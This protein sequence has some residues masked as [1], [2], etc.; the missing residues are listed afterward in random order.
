ME[1]FLN[2]ARLYRVS[3]AGVFSGVL[4]TVLCALLVAQLLPHLGYAQA[5]GLRVTCAPSQA[6]VGRDEPVTWRAT[7]RGTQSPIAYRWRGVNITTVDAPQVTTSYGSYGTKEATVIVVSNGERAEAT[8]EV[9]VKANINLPNIG[10]QG[11]QGG[12]PQLPGGGNNP[13]GNLGNILGGNQQ[14]GQGGIPPAVQNILGGGNQ[15]GTTGSGIEPLEPVQ[16]QIEQPDAPGR[17]GDIIRATGE[18]DG[19]GRPQ[20]LDQAKNQCNQSTASS[21]GGTEGS[22][23]TGGTPQATGEYAVP[24]DTLTINAYIWELV[25]KD[26]GEPGG[27]SKSYD[28][29]DNCVADAMAASV[30]ESAGKY[31]QTAFNGNPAYVE[32][33][34][35]ALSDLS[36]MH[37][38]NFINEYQQSQRGSGNRNDPVPQN[39]IASEYGVPLHKQPKPQQSSSDNPWDELAIRLNP[40]NSD[41][42]RYLSAQA[43]VE[44][45]QANAIELQLAEYTMN[46]GYLSKKDAETGDVEIPGSFLKSVSENRIGLAEYRL[47]GIDE[48]G[49][50]LLQPLQDILSKPPSQLLQAGS[51][52]RRDSNGGLLPG[53]TIPFNP[54]TT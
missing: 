26:A 14:G 18:A 21:I 53:Q 30:V 29:A 38:E 9:E 12:M 19:Q 40:A 35:R 22:G 36:Q 34:P 27:G 20:N 54:P 28:A 2:K 31:I 44:S 46:D 7:V 3:Y 16:P 50:E 32:N 23:V 1:R 25:R 45:I 52:P 33:L 37:F 11:G 42:L 6:E 15:Q 13:L 24:V 48:K 41:V 49:E 17:D 39:L 10:Q 43:E 8:C 51:G 4:L 5:T 47:M